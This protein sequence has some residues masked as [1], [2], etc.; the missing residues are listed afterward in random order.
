[1]ETNFHIPSAFIKQQG[2]Q[3]K[4]VPGTYNYEI[5]MSVFV[6]VQVTL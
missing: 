4:M 5:L 6:S 3:Q 2:G 1:M